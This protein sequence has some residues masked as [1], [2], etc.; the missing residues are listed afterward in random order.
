MTYKRCRI[1][2]SEKPLDAFNR[3]GKSR[4][5]HDSR[6]RECSRGQ[7]REY[8]R[9]NP[10]KYREWEEGTGGVAQAKHAARQ[11]RWRA[12]N[13]DKRH[14]HRAVE[15]ALRSGRLVKPDACER[16]RAQASRIEAHHEDYTRRLDVQ[17]LCV[18]C[19]KAT[20]KEERDRAAAARVAMTETQETTNEPA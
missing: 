11:R 6:C 9:K 13:R 7:Q 10:D 16:C 18:A 3:S 4:D 17:W 12:E 19:H 2:G 8:R 15:I 14:A 5:G 1:C 20:H